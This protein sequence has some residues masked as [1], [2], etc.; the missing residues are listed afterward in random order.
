MNTQ[1][2]FAFIIAIVFFL[3]ACMPWL[4]KADPLDLSSADWP[5]KF[6]ALCPQVRGKARV[7]HLTLT[8][9]REFDGVQYS[10][11]WSRTTNCQT[12]SPISKAVVARVVDHE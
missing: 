6:P 12:V 10:Y 1:R 5:F 3:I 7:F 9:I 8:K 4:V 2:V 11:T